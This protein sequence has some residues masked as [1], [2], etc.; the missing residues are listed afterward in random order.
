MNMGSQKMIWQMLNMTNDDES[1]QWLVQ[2]WVVDVYDELAE[3]DLDRIRAAE[4]AILM[5]GPKSTEPSRY[6][7]LADQD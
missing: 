6:R 3:A 4:E 7:G 2:S 1:G 5:A